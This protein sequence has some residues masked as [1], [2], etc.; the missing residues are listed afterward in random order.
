VRTR[1]IETRDDLTPQERQIAL[2]ARDG[3]TNSDIGARLV[4]SRHTMA[5]HL[6]KVFVKLGIGSRRE[7]A[8]A[9]P[10]S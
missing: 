5:D 1:V 6:H 2:L 8:A 7:L 10:R 9:L 4:L 3:M